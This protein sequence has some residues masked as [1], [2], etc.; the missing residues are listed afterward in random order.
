VTGS[1]ENCRML[2]VPPTFTSAVFL[3]LLKKWHHTPV[4]SNGRPVAVDNIIPI[5][6]VPKGCDCSTPG[7]DAGS[8]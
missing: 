8:G 6:L 3:E 1:L 7:G 2:Q 5:R 4:L